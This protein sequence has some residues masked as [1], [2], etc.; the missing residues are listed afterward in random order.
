MDRRYEPKV[1]IEVDKSYNCGVYQIRNKVNGNVYIGSSKH[2]R[3]RCKDHFC[4]LKNKKH[5]NPHL[6]RAYNK[7]G[8]DNLVFEVIEFCSPEER[9]EIEQYWIDYFIGENCYNINPMASKPPDCTG[10]KFIFSEEHRKNLS[11]SIKKRFENPKL[12]EK[13][14]LDRIGKYL[15]A[16]HPNSK[17]VVCLETGKVY[18]A[19]AEASRE[20]GVERRAI[21]NCCTHQYKTSNGLHWLFKEEYDQ[22]SPEEIEEFLFTENRSKQVV[23]LETRTKYLKVIDAATDTG[24]DRSNIIDCCE[25]IMNEAKGTHWAYYHDYK[26]MTEEDI[27]EK[28][29]KHTITQ[30]R[31]MCMETGQVFNSLAEAEKVMGLPN[32]KVVEVCRGRRKTT[33]GYHF[34]Y[35][36][37]H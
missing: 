28:L 1:F 7:Y 12:R 9:F 4:H 11:T 8:E 27:Q 24:V 25:G 37:N 22:L 17:P 32:G 16:E 21:S 20:T 23:H 14:R 26:D 6:Q 3:K 5:D 2:L 29:S 15:G 31:C 18:A 30:R 19:Q 35:I 33:G 34:Q 13:F 36:S 10:K